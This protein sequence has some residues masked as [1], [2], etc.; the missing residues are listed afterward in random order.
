MS[1]QS[2]WCYSGYVCR[3]KNTQVQTTVYSNKTIL[4]RIRVYNFGMVLLWLWPIRLTTTM[5]TEHHH[6]KIDNFL[7]AYFLNDKI[8]AYLCELHF[9]A[10]FDGICRKYKQLSLIRNN[11]KKSIIKLSVWKFR[12]IINKNSKLS[13]CVHELHQTFE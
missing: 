4:E 7:H 10:L 6:S 8:T 13:C 12:K 11:N 5:I 2:C 3:L 9:Q 1:W